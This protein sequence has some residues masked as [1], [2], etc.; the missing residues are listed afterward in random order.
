MGV[1][2]RV[3]VR[4][5]VRVEVRVELAREERPGLA[6][7]GARAEQT[8]FRGR[9]DLVGA[10]Y[11]RAGYVGAGDVAAGDGLVGASDELVGAGDEIVGARDEIVGAELACALVSSR[12]HAAGRNA[13]AAAAP[14]NGIAHALHSVTTR[15]CTACDVHVVTTPCGLVFTGR[16][17]STHRG[18]LVDRLVHVGWANLGQGL[19]LS[20]KPSEVLPVQQRDARYSQHVTEPC[21]AIGSEYCD[22]LRVRAQEVRVAARVL[23]RKDQASELA[24]PLLCLCRSSSRKSRARVQPLLETV[25]HQGERVWQVCRGGKKE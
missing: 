8:C 4:V 6:A 3:G 24:Q 12:D 23:L 20:N 7:E 16:L 9:D 5:R 14:D 10:G 15:L 2:V 22:E 1:G 13:S 17:N 11:V 25:C 21:L 19:C 18:L